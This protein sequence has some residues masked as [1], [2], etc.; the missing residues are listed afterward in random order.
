LPVEEVC[1]NTFV[2]LT[3]LFGSFDMQTHT[4]ERCAEVEDVP[5][6]S[7]VF[8][9]AFEPDSNPDSYG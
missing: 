8:C 7:W 5:S 4:F 9:G 3:Y 2:L 6:V 1:I